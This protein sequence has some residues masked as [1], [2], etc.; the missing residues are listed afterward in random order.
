[1]PSSSS[2]PSPTETLKVLKDRRKVAL[3]LQD[4]DFPALLA[5]LEAA[6]R[7]P[8]PPTQDNWL[9]RRAWADGALDATLKCKNQFDLTLIDRA[10]QQALE[11]QK[12]SLDARPVGMKN[13]YPAPWDRENRQ[14]V[15]NPVDSH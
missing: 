4:T 15:D 11:E 7:Q 9:V 6:A 5:A 1:M 13:P 2:Q 10:I 12:A 8:V 14:N 3:L